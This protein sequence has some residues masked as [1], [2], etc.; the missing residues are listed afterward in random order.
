MPLPNWGSV[1][2]HLTV[3]KRTQTTLIDGDKYAHIPVDE[4]L[5]L[6]VASPSTRHLLEIP[7]K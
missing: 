3:W 2:N 6:A 7:K 4:R 5:E 1:R